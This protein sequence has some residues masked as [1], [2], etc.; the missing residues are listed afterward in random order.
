M[1]IQRSVT[2]ES[3]RKRTI[4]E[5]IEASIMAACDYFADRR[6]IIGRVVGLESTPA[7]SLWVV[8]A[9]CKRV[10]MLYSIPG[11]EKSLKGRVRIV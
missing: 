1:N 10:W 7:S 2:K 3:F 5:N 4:E 9:E 6:G 11:S 8:R